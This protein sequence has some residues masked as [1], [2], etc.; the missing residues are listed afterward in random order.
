MLFATFWNLIAH[1][2]KG[3]IIAHALVHSAF[4]AE[5]EVILA[6]VLNIR[7]DLSVN[8]QNKP[9]IGTE[10]EPSIFTR[11]VISK[12]V[13]DIPLDV[14]DKKWHEGIIATLSKYSF[15]WDGRIWKIGQQNTASTLKR[16]YSMSGRI[17]TGWSTRNANSRGGDQQDSE[18]RINQTLKLQMGIYHRPSSK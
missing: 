11:N 18:C 17:V 10:K 13:F 2:H 12:S 14:V 15:M 4:L 1:L 16:T 5:T 7:V 9:S 3:K 8:A 6:E